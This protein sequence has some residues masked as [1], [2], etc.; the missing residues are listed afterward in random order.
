MNV[1]NTYFV[2]IWKRVHF[3]N[4]ENECEEQKIM[5]SWAKN[6]TVAPGE[7]RRGAAIENLHKRHQI[8]FDLSNYVYHPGGLLS[9]LDV[10]EEHTGMV[11][12][13]RQPDIDTRGTVLRG[14]ALW[15]K[16]VPHAD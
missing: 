5:L 15:T 2:Y 11:S 9:A 13:R 16:C 1:K 7:G 10:G 3:L 6:G 4:L 12:I 14:L 8:T